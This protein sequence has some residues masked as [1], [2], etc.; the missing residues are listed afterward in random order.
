M[1]ACEGAGPP[2]TVA[3]GCLHVAHHRLELPHLIRLE[4]DMLLLPPVKPLL[5]DA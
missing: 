2:L 3:S 1:L 5:R 4:A